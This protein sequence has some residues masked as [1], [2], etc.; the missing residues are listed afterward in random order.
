MQHGIVH[1]VW[2]ST[3]HYIGFQ[4]TLT[5]HNSGGS[6]VLISQLFLIRTYE[7]HDV[8]Q[9]ISKAAFE[10]S[11]NNNIMIIITIKV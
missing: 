7:C 4:L 10:Q 11:C 6:P 5:L 1:A 8:M 3:S 2:H 9:N